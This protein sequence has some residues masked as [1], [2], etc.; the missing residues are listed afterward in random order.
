MSVP[1]FPSAC[2]YVPCACVPYGVTSEAIPES[3]VINNRLKASTS[4][5]ARPGFIIL[6]LVTAGLSCSDRSIVSNVLENGFAG[7]LL[8]LL[9]ASSSDTSDIIPSKGS[10]SRV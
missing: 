2:E 4:I 6:G 1:L 3:P 9:S 5:E 7:A 8:G 10:C